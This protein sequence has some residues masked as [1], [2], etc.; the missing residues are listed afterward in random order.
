MLFDNYNLVSPL[1]Q[2]PEKIKQ[3]EKKESRKIQTGK[4]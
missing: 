1:K 4:Y 3:E 2:Y